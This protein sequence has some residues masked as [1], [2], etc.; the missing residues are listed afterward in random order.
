MP[1]ERD[2]K[3]DCKGGYLLHINHNEALVIL[4][5]VRWRYCDLATLRVMRKLATIVSKEW[6]QCADSWIKLE[7]DA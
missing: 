6:V 7:E 3:R 2:L 5:T 1:R 4:Q